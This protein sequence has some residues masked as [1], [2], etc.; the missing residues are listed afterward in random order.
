MRVRRHS[1]RVSL[2][3]AAAE[4]RIPTNMTAEIME[5]V[6]LCRAGIGP[7][8]NPRRRLERERVMRRRRWRVT[9]AM[10]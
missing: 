5:M 4:R 7:R 9:A 6:K 3:S 1:H 8:E 2:I 10:M